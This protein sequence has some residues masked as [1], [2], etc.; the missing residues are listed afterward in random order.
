MAITRW[1]ADKTDLCRTEKYTEKNY[2]FG[3]NKQL[4]YVGGRL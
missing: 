2:D 3:L 1:V 4:C